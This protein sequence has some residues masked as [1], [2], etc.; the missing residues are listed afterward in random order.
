V[1]DQQRSSPRIDADLRVAY[2]SIDDLVVAYCADLSQGG[3]FLSSDLLL[4]VDSTVRVTLELPDGAGDI[5]LLCRVAWSREPMQAAHE[6]KPTGMGLQ[7]LDVPDD[8]LILIEAFISER[9][10]ADMDKVSP[11]R[12]E[13]RLSVLI[14]DDDVAGQKLAAA[15][16]RARGDYVRLA[17]DGL[18]ALA[19]ALKE[20]PDII[21][22][23]VNM[24]RMDGWQLLRMV[25]ARP[26]L[27]AVPVIFLSTLAGEEERL[28]GY[29]LGVDDFVHKPYRSV[30]LRARVDRLTA[31]TRGSA[32]KEERNALRGDLAQVSLPSLFTFLE[33]E[34]K[35]G[36]LAVLNE[37]SA[38]VYVRDGRPLRVEVEDSEP[39]FSSSELMSIVLGWSAGQF[40]FSAEPIDGEDQMQTS[41]TALL[42][43]HARITD[44]QN[45]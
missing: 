4:P 34:R 5:P 40:D 41:F 15:P 3:M 19:L 25:R 21:L 26:S 36:R 45:R 13:K 18:E 28:K 33:L 35:T 6:K 42:L 8:T 2:R 30:E 43:E 38:Y 37:K 24:P 29:Q 14:V 7:F 9:M 23:D 44:E 27:Q 39:Y 1:T 22:S 32:R 12:A 31:R 20:P 11:I 17:G 10:A 16:F